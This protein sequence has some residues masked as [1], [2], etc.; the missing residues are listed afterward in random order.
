MWQEPALFE[1][2]SGGCL[3]ARCKRID[4]SLENMKT[5]II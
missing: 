3:P 4:D 1:V 5:G 2:Y